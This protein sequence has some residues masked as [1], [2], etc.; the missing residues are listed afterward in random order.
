MVVITT[1]RPPES[2]IRY[3]KDNVLVV[4]DK[5]AL[6]TGTLY[7]SEK[8]LSWNKRGNEGFSMDYYNVSLHAISKDPNVYDGE[9]IY[10]LTDPHIDMLGSGDNVHQA[11]DDNDDDVA[12]DSDPN[13]SEL[14]LVPNST[15]YIQGIYDAIKVC[16]E[17]NPDPADV[18]EDDDDDNQY[19]D[20][21]DEGI[22]A[23]PEPIGDAVMDH[24]AQQLQQNS[25]QVLDRFRNGHE[26]EDEE[27][28]DAD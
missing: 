4:L 1:F 5:V 17:L 6:G 27:F 26:I 12:S 7:V 2:P 14:V 10:I 23:D 22:I 16:Q 11:V 8:T 13:L 21:E 19:A 9:C 24:L 15:E 18:D 20:A 28:E 3:E 25:V